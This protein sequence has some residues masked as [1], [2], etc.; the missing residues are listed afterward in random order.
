MSGESASREIQPVHL[1]VEGDVDVFVDAIPG[2]KAQGFALPV[3]NPAGGVGHVQ[4]AMTPLERIETKLEGREIIG[5]GRDAHAR[6]QAEG[7]LEKLERVGICDCGFVAGFKRGAK[8]A[9]PQAR[10][11]DALLVRNV[12]QSAGEVELANE[13]ER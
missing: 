9:R 8:L 3:E 12:V 13:V 5:A 7:L 6:P 10:L 1:I 2:A 4:P 11:E